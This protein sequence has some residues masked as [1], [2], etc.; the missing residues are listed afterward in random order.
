MR[1]FSHPAKEALGILHNLLCFC[2][3][4]QLTGS[5]LHTAWHNPPHIWLHTVLP[6]SLH[7]FLS[8][9]PPE[10]FPQL[11]A[12]LSCQNDSSVW[13]FLHRKSRRNTRFINRSLVFIFGGSAAHTHSL[14]L[15]LFLGNPISWSHFHSG[16][17][18]Y[19]K[20]IA[21]PVNLYVHP[22]SWRSVSYSWHVSAGKWKW[23][24]E[25][26]ILILGRLFWHVT[27]RFGWFIFCQRHRI[28]SFLLKMTFMHYS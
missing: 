4:A 11:L 18:P 9:L 1:A 22:S 3:A 8:V 28:I 15:I 19:S 16:C 12:S 26:L 13:L 21:L 25:C 20:L 10:R 5:L 27:W 7:V 14:S 17:S 24:V 23:D 6:S 2:T